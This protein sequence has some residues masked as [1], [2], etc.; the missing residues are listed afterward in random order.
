M[1][2]PV[3]LLSLLLIGSFATAADTAPALPAAPPPTAKVF[4]V[5]DTAGI[6]KMVGQEITV[7]GKVL[8][9]FW[10]RDNVLMITFREDKQGF[11][12]VSFAKYREKLDQAF[13]ASIAEALKGK[14]VNLKGKV[15]SYNTRPQIVI[16]T[17]D[18]IEI[19]ND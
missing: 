1:K 7:T 9:S 5:D 10:V 19:L 16:E 12:A 2:L 11:L 8:N 13:D 14:K 17:A 3:C 4:D 15:T 18:Q 6:E